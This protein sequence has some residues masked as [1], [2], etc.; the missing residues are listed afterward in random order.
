ML[1]RYDVIWNSQSESS[2]GSMPVG[3]YDCGA[4]VWVENGDVLLYLDRSGSF[5][6]N[7]QM[8]KLGRFRLRTAPA[9]FERH[10]RQQLCLERGSVLVEGDDG[11]QMEIWFHT[12]EPCLRIDVRSERE[13][14]LLTAYECWRTEETEIGSKNPR[15]PFSY[16]G[17]KGKVYTYPDEIEAGKERLTFRHQNR[18]DKLLFDFLVKQQGLEAVRDQL[19]NP[20]KDWIFGGALLGEGLA[21]S[22]EENAEYAG[23]ACRRYWYRQAPAREH[24]LT[25]C[26]Y[27]V[28]GS[29]EQ[30]QT[31]LEEAVR[32]CSA[33]KDARQTALD[34]WKQFWQRSYIH[35]NEEALESDEG[36][37]IGRNFALMRYMQG[38]NAYGEY[39]TKFNGGLF[40]TDAVCWGGEEWAGETPDYR[41]WGGGSFTAQNQRLVYWPMLKNG[42]FDLM[43]PQFEYYLRALP[44][45]EKRS[46]VYWGHGGCAF[47]EQVENMGLPVGI[48][49]GFPESDT[50][51][52]VRPDYMEPELRCP[53][54]RYEYVTVLEFVYMILE[55]SRYSG[56]SIERYQPLIDSSLRF[57]REHYEMI[58]RNNANRPLDE[59][60][61]WV[62]WPST[63]LETYKDAMNP[64]E[65]LS[66]LQAV[67]ER[68]CEITEGEKQAEYA[69]MLA[70]VPP[71][72][73]RVREG[74]ECIAPAWSFNTIINSELPQL[75]PVYPY[76]QYGL[77]REKLELARNTYWHGVDQEEQRGYVS[78]RQDGIFAARL[79]LTGEAVRIARQKLTDGEL[80]FPAFWGPGYDWLPDHN[81]GGSGMIGVQEML[82]QQTDETVYLLPA[83]PKEWTVSFRQY[84][85]GGATAEVEWDGTTLRWNIVGGQA[86]R[87]ILPDGTATEQRQ[88]SREITG[89]QKE[90]EKA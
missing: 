51:F 10:F 87:V 28:H 5:D 45:A 60:G 76:G 68:L 20:Q 8:L 49:W 85:P 38:C 47:P 53:W 33:R 21:F 65:V 78:W 86:R 46:E 4:N 11:F 35:I 18:N 3:G 83:W 12:D 63:A 44:N 58:H 13:V 69:A 40:T 1:K 62:I 41:R 57:F 32:R 77:G 19:D 71:V 29:A 2:A 22:G 79:G 15:S 56:A 70:K 66:A 24:H 64:T 16:Q 73:I 23:I 55:Y 75:Y 34:W 72:A 84:L 61:H 42:D 89:W 31:G 39:P 43:P 9:C 7:N 30:W 36:F 14:E 67:L 82:V 80:R 27:A 26:P 90:E 74:V 48:C 6:E 52:Y 59:D 54:T 50:P 25:V 81:W 17:Y 37:Q 88:G